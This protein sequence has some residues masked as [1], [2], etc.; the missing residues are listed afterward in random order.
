MCLW[1][2]CVQLCLDTHWPQWAAVWQLI[3]GNPLCDSQQVQWQ[4][5][6]SR[7]PL[8]T[9]P[10]TH[11]SHT[12]TQHSLTSSHNAHKWKLS[13]FIYL[14]ILLNYWCVLNIT[15][16]LDS[17]ISKKKNSAFH[18]LLI[19]DS[20]LSNSLLRAVFTLS[21]SGGWVVAAW[22]LVAYR[23]RRLDTVSVVVSLWLTGWQCSSDLTSLNPPCTPPTGV[24]NTICSA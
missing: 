15:E 12:D 22:F 17:N 20:L 14:E 18:K 9:Q 11:V 3:L 21:K 5:L 1:C 16:Q 4:Q 24:T 10:H 23:Q 19:S 7:E 2:S 13:L 8:L 6:F